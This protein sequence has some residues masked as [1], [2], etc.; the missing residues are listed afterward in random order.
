MELLNS[1]S[2]GSFKVNGHRLKPLWRLFPM[3]RRNS[4]FLIHIKLDKTISFYGLSLSKDYR[5]HIF[6]FYFLFE[7]FPVLLLVLILISC[8]NFILVWFN[9]GFLLSIAGGTSKQLG[10]SLKILGR[11]KIKTIRTPCENFVRHAKFM[12][13]FAHPTNQFHTLCEN[14]LTLRTHFAHYAKFLQSM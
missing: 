1:N 12:A 11:E 10:V 14:K 8:F 4:S 3:T 2:T 13:H 7:S 5:V 6:L 9:L